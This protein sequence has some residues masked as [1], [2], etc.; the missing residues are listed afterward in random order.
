[1]HAGPADDGARP[2]ADEEQLGGAGVCRDHR[3]HERDVA[4]A[5]VQAQ[6]EVDERAQVRPRRDPVDPHGRS[7]RCT[8]GPAA[9]P[10][11]PVSR[12]SGVKVG[13]WPIVLPSARQ[14]PLL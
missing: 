1:M 13:M 10:A 7:G 4:P 14:I 9:A 5:R 11:P 8:G 6:R 3:R 2:V 12:E